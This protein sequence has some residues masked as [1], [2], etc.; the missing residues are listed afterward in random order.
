M[1][2]LS[3]PGTLCRRISKK[4]SVALTCHFECDRA[5]DCGKVTFT[6][7]AFE[8]DGNAETPVA[9]NFQTHRGQLR[10][11]PRLDHPSRGS[12][13]DTQGLSNCRLPLGQPDLRTPPVDS[14]RR[15]DF[16]R[17][18][19]F[20]NLSS[21]SRADKISISPGMYTPAKCCSAPTVIMRPII[22]SVSALR[23]HPRRCCRANP[24]GKR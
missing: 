2:R 14:H 23:P 21:I 6:A 10:Y 1:T 12:G 17:P 9:P 16:F 19:C 8:P 5:I 20:A 4:T 24:G 3:L 13:G 15:F 7:E 18:G 22:L 11:L